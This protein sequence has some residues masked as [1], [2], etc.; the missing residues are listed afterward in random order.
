MDIDR[1]T[2]SS[3]L[4]TTRDMVHGYI[5][6]HDR[7]RSILFRQREYAFYQEERSHRSRTHCSPADVDRGVVV[8]AVDISTYVE[9]GPNDFQVIMDYLRDLL[10]KVVPEQHTIL[11]LFIK[12]AS[13][14]KRLEFSNLIMIGWLRLTMTWQRNTS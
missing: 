7:H 6:L 13:F 2:S 8:L 10:K 14:R 3:F 4:P 5:K 9:T 1:I 11:L 12:V